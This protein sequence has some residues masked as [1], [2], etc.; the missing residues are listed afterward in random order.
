MSNKIDEIRAHREAVRL[1][2]KADGG[3]SWDHNGYLLG[4]VERLTKERDAARHALRG[5]AEGVEGAA[6]VAET[7]ADGRGVL[8]FQPR[9]A[10]ADVAKM[11]RASLDEVREALGKVE[12]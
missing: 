2:Q 8:K 5:L 6:G 10:L 7:T 4:E 9:A 12:L 3:A 11:L 1:G